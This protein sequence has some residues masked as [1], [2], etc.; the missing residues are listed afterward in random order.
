MREVLNLFIQ[1]FKPFRYIIYL[2]IVLTII[3]VLLFAKGYL[4]TP[5]SQLLWLSDSIVHH[6]NEHIKPVD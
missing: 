3:N 5:E 6:N 4:D 2:L 1:I